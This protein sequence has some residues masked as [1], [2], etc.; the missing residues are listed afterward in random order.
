MKLGTANSGRYTSEMGHFAGTELIIST[1]TPK[2]SLRTALLRQVPDIP[3]PAGEGCEESA[4]AG[5]ASWLG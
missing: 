1:A 4:G 5:L 2:G 3:S